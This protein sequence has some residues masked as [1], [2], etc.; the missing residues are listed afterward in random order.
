MNKYAHQLLEDAI[1]RDEKKRKKLDG[2]MR[3]TV[4]MDSLGR[5]SG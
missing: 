4:R 3:L 1:G 2:L 5:R